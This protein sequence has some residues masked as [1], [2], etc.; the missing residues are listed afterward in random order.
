MP[1]P[2]PCT[3]RVTWAALCPG[4]R[5]DDCPKWHHCI[6]SGPHAQ[7]RVTWQGREYT[8]APA[9]GGARAGAGRPR[10]APAELASVRIVAKATPAEAEEIEAA[11]GKLSAGAYVLAAGLRSARRRR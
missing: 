10:K 9:R 6:E 2:K 7:H 1:P 8:W 5:P 11:R 3:A 4:P